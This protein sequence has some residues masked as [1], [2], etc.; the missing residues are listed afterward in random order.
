MRMLRGD[1]RSTFISPIAVKGVRRHYFVEIMLAPTEYDYF[2]PATGAPPPKALI[3]ILSLTI[4]YIKDK[5]LY[6]I[7][8]LVSIVSISFALN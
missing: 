3:F 1:K 7:T 6:S 8:V 5:Y 2:Q 4:G